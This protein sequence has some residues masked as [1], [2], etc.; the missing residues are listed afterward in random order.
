MS[1]STQ[2]YYKDY[3]YISRHSNVPYYYNTEDSK[4]VMGLTSHID[5]NVTYVTYKVKQGD[6]YDSISLKY[7]NSPLYYWVIL[8][9]NE[10]QD[11]LE[12]PATGTLLKI[13]T[14]N[15]ITYKEI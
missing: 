2:K 15:A 11:P 14:L 5:K 8:D 4:Y 10:I 9:Y 13:P 12:K 6:S 3:G 1:E 7:Y